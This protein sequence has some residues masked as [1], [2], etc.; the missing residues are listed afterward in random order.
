MNTKETEYIPPQ[1]DL[2]DDRLFAAIGYLGILCLVPLLLKKDSAFAQHHG[3]QGLVILLAWLVLWVGNII[4]IL[5]QIVWTL[6]TLALLILIILGMINAL[7]G[8]MWEMPFL[9][10]YAKDLK[11]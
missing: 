2:P 11:I 9:G 5:G 7:Q 10:K 8:K 3:K 4:P 1:G 6:G